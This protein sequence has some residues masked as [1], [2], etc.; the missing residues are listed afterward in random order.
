MENRPVFRPIPFISFSIA[1]N[2]QGFNDTRGTLFFEIARVLRD[3][4]PRYFLL[5]NV[6]NLLSHD[7]GRTVKKIFEVCDEL[8][9]DVS[10][11]IYNS[12]DYGVP[13]NRERIFIKGYFRDKCGQ[14]ILSNR[15]TVKE[16][17]GNLI[18][19]NERESIDTNQQ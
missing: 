10:W 13:Q 6:K 14:E 18:E 5:E 11:A 17:T 4:T 1:G 15:G 9:Y 12:K 19:N 16:T 3:K 2:R 7:G 8:G